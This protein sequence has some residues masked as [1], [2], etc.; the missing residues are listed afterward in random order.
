MALRPPI[1]ALFNYIILIIL[2]L[3]ANDVLAADSKQ[4][5]GT[6]ADILRNSMDNVAALIM[7]VSYVSGIAF[8]MMGLYKLKTHK[9]QPTQVPLSQPIVLLVL[10]ACLV[11]LPSVVKTTGKTLWADQTITTGTSGGSHDS[12][13]F[14]QIP[15]VR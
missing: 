2:L 12:G 14:L 3:S 8:S 1:L 9:D 15:G 4:T 10:G 7:A 5:V 6:V 13:K 11:F